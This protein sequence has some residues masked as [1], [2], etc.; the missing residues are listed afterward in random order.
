M[1]RAAGR[2]LPVNGESNERSGLSYQSDRRTQTH[3]RALEYFSSYAVPDLDQLY[4][5][6]IAFGGDAVDLQG[7][8]Y[9]SCDAGLDSQLVLLDLRSD[10]DSGR[11]ACRSL[12]AP[13][14][15]RI[16]DDFLGRIPG[17][18]RGGHE[19]VGIAA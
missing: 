14:R 4:R 18:C 5:S 19:L 3:R 16:G 1:G 8:R 12:Q 17:D 2:N 10:A 11:H 13:D 7:V 6:R 15:D 9:R